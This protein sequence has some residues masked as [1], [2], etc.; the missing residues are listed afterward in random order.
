MRVSSVL[1]FSYHTCICSDS[2]IPSQNGSSLRKHRALGTEGYGAV[3]YMLRICMTKGVC[4]Q[5]VLMIGK[6]MLR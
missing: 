4:T 2:L 3:Y 1:W 5:T 6:A